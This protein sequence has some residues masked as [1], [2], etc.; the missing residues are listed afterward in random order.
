MFH[1]SEDPR[2]PLPFDLQEIFVTPWLNVQDIKSLYSN[3]SEA[4]CSRLQELLLFY[5]HKNTSLPFENLS[6]IFDMSE[7]GGLGPMTNAVLWVEAVICAIFVGLRL[8]TR[9]RILN[10]VGVDDYL[11]VLAFVRA[12][13]VI[14]I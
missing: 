9:I 1:N 5:H 10:S 2:E 6:V 4:A 13:T 7:Y 3:R 11:V 12:I 8:Y 14:L